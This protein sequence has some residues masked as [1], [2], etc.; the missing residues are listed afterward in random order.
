[1]FSVLCCA[2][3]TFAGPATENAVAPRP[4]AMIQFKAAQYTIT[5]AD[6]AR[7]KNKT[8]QAINLYKDALDTYMRLAR[9]YP[10]WQPGVTEFRIAYCNDQLESL[11]TQLDNGSG[12]PQ[13]TPG[14]EDGPHLETVSFELDS[15]AVRDSGNDAEV[16]TTI[17]TARFLLKQE[18]T[19][20]ARS[21]LL[22]GLRQDPD[23]RDIRLMMGIV[24]CQSEEF[25]SALHLIRQL[26][27]DNPSDAEAY[28]VLGTAYFGL[29]RLTSTRASLERA[30]KID[31]GLSEAHY[32]LAQVLISLKKPEK[33]AAR[34]HYNKALEL[35]GKRDKKLEAQF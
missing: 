26:I 22:K 9:S 15:F 8:T 2:C 30:L 27:K 12:S 5:M 11:L 29:G 13:N 20:K 35:G 33:A 31:Q 14:Q 7:A 28:I 1:M 6:E 3:A 24:H 32:N 19:E 17:A 23:D 34:A 10:N 4:P 25:E 16:G 21:V 18:D